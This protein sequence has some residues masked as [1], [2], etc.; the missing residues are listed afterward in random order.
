MCCQMDNAI[1]GFNDT[2]VCNTEKITNEKYLQ[3]Q[4]NQ[5]LMQQIQIECLYQGTSLV[6]TNSDVIHLGK[7]GSCYLQ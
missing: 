7:F 4:T 5:N 2:H 6:I 1:V 3:A